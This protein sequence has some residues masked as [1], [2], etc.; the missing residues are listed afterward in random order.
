MNIYGL[1]LEVV[2]E[3]FKVRFDFSRAC[4]EEALGKGLPFFT[5]SNYFKCFNS[6]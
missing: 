4:I 3:L 5:L 2:G 1:C 6:Y